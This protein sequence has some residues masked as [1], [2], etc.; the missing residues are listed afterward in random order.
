MNHHN[1]DRCGKELLK[2]SD[3][4]YEVRIEVKAA[5]DPLNVTE[6]DLAKNFR[7]E[8]ARMLQ[9][10][11]GISVAEAQNQVYR[12]FEFDLCP[13]C[14]RAYIRNPLESSRRWP[15]SRLGRLL[16]EPTNGE[17]DN[18]GGCNDQSFFQG[19]FFRPN[20]VARNSHRTN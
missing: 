15:L 1:C 14:Q 10:L 8:I 6:E 7:E 20:N 19:H 18:S 3:V 9:Q 11:E 12:L 13:A 17:N 4:R 5:Y 2:D 16:Q